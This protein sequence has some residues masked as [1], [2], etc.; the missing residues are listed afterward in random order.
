VLQQD[1]ALWELIIID[2]SSTD[3]SL[4]LAQSHSDVRIRCISEPE[5]GVSR[6]RNRGLDL[7]RGKYIC[8]LDADDRL[9]AGSL[10]SRVT[11]AEEHQHLAIIDGTVVTYNADFSEATARWLPRFTGNPADE[12]AMHTGTCFRGVTAMVRRSALGTVRFPINQSHAEDLSFYL[13]LALSGAQYGYVEDEVYHI[14]QRPGS[15]M[16]NLEGLSAGYEALLPLIE[17]LHPAVQAEYK[18]RVRKIVFRSA[19]KRGHI[20]LALRSLSW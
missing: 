8:F 17:T 12:L 5:R 18:K 10:S 4:P 9:P 20:G 6:A 1:Y 3:A 14:R 15:A 2:N 7:A 19:L 11:Y 16:S 13:Q